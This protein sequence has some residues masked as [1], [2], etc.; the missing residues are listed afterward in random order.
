MTDVPA[1]VESVLSQLFEEAGDAFDRGDV[2]TAVSAVATASEVATNKLPD[3]EFRS[4]LLH[5]CER[6]EAVATGEDGDTAAA[7]EYVAAMERRLAEAAS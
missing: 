4:Q 1:D 3:S 5:G 7:A 2:E 6:A